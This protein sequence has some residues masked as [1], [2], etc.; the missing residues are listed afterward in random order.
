ML[1]I[2]EE[3]DVRIDLANIVS[4][5]HRIYAIFHITNKSAA[6]ASLSINSCLYSNLK[7]RYYS[8]VT[9][10]FDYSG[11]YPFE[12]TGNYLIPAGYFKELQVIYEGEAINA[13][14]EFDVVFAFSL[15]NYKKSLCIGLHFLAIEDGWEITAVPGSKF[16]DDEFYNSHKDWKVIGH[17]SQ[18]NEAQRDVIEKPYERLN[19]L[20]VLQSVKDEVLALANFVKVQKLRESKGMKISP[21]SYHCVFTGNPGTGKTTVARIVASIYKELGILKKGHLIE[22]DRSGLVGNYVGHTATKTHSVIDSAL[23]GVLFIDEAYAL[24]SSESKQ[25]FGPE[26]IATL[27][28][29]MEDNR[30]RLVV[31]LAGYSKEMKEFIES[32]SGLKSRFV[33]YIDFPDYNSEEL[34]QIMMLNVEDGGYKL[35]EAAIP[36]LKEAF[37]S[38]INSGDKNYGNGRYVRNLYEE[39]LK[40]QANRIAVLPDITDD[41]L[42]IITMT[43]VQIALSKVVSQIK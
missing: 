14:D 43:D 10:V 1:K 40:A 35:E 3:N 16:K 2:L 25:D 37:D 13:G 7:F 21:I 26:A 31:I 33:R 15:L 42:T 9:G 4:S 24:A 36:V 20:I 22:T 8:K 18:E 38:I 30:D 32:N 27:L 29:R 41:D 19:S 39:S 34:L 28:K 5:N 17:Y 12:P 11:V 23:D 6:E